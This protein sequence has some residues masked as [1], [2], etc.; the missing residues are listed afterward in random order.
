M[1]GKIKLEKNGD[2][3]NFTLDIVK[4][5]DK[6]VYKVWQQRTFCKFLKSKSLPKILKFISIVI[7]NMDIVVISF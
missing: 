1:T 6:P 3:H 7:F 5:K 2:R 4:V